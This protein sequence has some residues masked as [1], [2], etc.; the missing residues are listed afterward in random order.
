MKPHVV[1][2]FHHSLALNRFTV[3]IVCIVLEEA[4]A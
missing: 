2:P 1:R 4:I 3:C